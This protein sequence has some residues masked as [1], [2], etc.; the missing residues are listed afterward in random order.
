MAKASKPPEPKP[1][2]TKAE[3]FKDSATKRVQKVLN[4]L[5]L[6][7]KCS[8]RRTNEFT[9]DEVD[10]MFGAIEQMTEKCKMQFEPHAE[11]E[12]AKFSF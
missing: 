11:T 3:R 10:Q 2:K 4:D 5:A 6:L 12:E 8:N 7:S 1:K 9:Q